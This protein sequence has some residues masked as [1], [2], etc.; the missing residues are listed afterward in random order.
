MGRPRTIDALRRSHNAANEPDWSLMQELSD[1]GIGVSP[2][3]VM[4]IF[5]P[6][7]CAPELR[8]AIWRAYCA[9][10]TSVDSKALGQLDEALEEMQTR[11][12]EHAAQLRETAPRCNWTS[13]GVPGNQVRL[14]PLLSCS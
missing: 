9:V 10:A 7:V 3:S 4:P 1:A 12:H 5:D 13:L 2:C 14:L 11:L 6:S 8:T